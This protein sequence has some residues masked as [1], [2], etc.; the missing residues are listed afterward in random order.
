MVGSYSGCPQVMLS[1][2]SKPLA[3]VALSQSIP[4][5]HPFVHELQVLIVA[6]LNHLRVPYARYSQPLY[7]FIFH[8][9]LLTQHRLHLRC[10]MQTR[11]IDR[12]LGD[13]GI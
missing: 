13:P 9:S 3:T 7:F 1:L 12:Y 2:V 4:R 11:C 10:S 5:L 6:I 8:I